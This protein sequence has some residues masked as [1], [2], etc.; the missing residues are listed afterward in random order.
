[1]LYINEINLRLKHPLSCSI[2]LSQSIALIASKPF[3]EDLFVD[4]LRNNP[5]EADP[6]FNRDGK[7]AAA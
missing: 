6:V 5:L 3:K 1:M 4:L 7:I 2:K